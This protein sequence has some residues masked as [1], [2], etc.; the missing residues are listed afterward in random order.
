MPTPSY[1]QPIVDD[2]LQTVD[3]V[4]L[5]SGPPDTYLN[6]AQLSGQERLD[7]DTLFEANERVFPLDS[8][9]KMDAVRVVRN[10]VLVSFREAFAFKLRTRN[11]HY[12]QAVGGGTDVTVTSSAISDSTTAGRAMLTAADAGVQ[13]AF[14]GLGT[15]ATRPATDFASASL[16]VDATTSVKGLVKLAGGDIGGT[17]DSVQVLK[18]NGVAVTGTPVAGSVLTATSDTAAGWSALAAASLTTSGVV[19]LVDLQALGNNRKVIDGA[20]HIGRGN[21][22]NAN[23]SSVTAV[24]SLAYNVGLGTGATAVGFQALGTTTSTANYLTAVGYKAGEGATGSDLAAVGPFAAQSATGQHIVAL[25]SSAAQFASGPYSIHIGAAAGSYSSASNSMFAGPSAGQYATNSTHLVALGQGSARNARDAD[26]IVAIGAHTAANVYSDRV[27]AI[28]TN[29]GLNAGSDSVMVG[30]QAV[31]G[32]S[33]SPIL[34]GTIMTQTAPGVF[35]LSSSIPGA[36]VGAYVTV[37]VQAGG[38]HPG[39][40]AGQPMR[41]LINS[42]TELA[43][44]VNR[45]TASSNSLSSGSTHIYTEYVTNNVTAVGANAGQWSSASNA[46]YVGDTAGAYNNATY[47]TLIGTAAGMNN[48]GTS[49]TAYGRGAATNNNAPNV[50]S[51]GHNSYRL[52]INGNG[53]TAI[54]H[55]TAEEASDSVG[56]VAIGISALRRPGASGGGTFVGAF[57]SQYNTGLYCTAIGNNAGQSVIGSMIGSDGAF[58][59]TQTDVSGNW[60]I[61]PALN[62]SYI[63]KQ[64]IVRV[65]SAGTHTEFNTVG[66]LFSAKVIT[67]T[68]VN[69]NTKRFVAAG[70]NG[71]NATVTLLELPT[72]DNATSI[73]ANS[74]NDASNQVTL[75][76]TA[77]TELKVGNDQRFSIDQIRSAATNTALAKKVVNGKHVVEAVPLLSLAPDYITVAASRD[78]TAFDDDCVLVCAAGITLTIPAALTMKRGFV[79]FPAVGGSVTISAPVT[80]ALNDVLGATVT[81]SRINNTSGVG[82]MYTGTTDRWGVSGDDG[83][84]ATLPD[85]TSS[86]KGVLM[87]A[88]DIGGAAALPTVSAIKGVSTPTTAP[89]VGQ[90]LISTSPTQMAWSD[91]FA[92][93]TASGV[94]NLVDQQNLGLNRKVID[95][96]VIGRGNPLLASRNGNTII[97][98]QSNNSTTLGD[99]VTAIGRAALGSSTVDVSG[100]TAVGNAAGRANNKINFTGVGAWAGELNTGQNV[101]AVGQ[102]AGQRNTALNGTFVGTAAGADN[103]GSAA[104]GMGTAALQNNTGANAIGVGE[105]AGYFNTGSNGV[106]L[107][108]QT[109]RFGTSGERQLFIGTQTG[110][111]NIATDYVAIGAYAGRWQDSTSNYTVALGGFT[112]NN[113]EGQFNTIVGH[114]AGSLRPTALAT[115]VTITQVSPGVFTISPALA[116]IPATRLYAVVTGVT[117]TPHTA[118]GITSECPFAFTSTT[119]CTS[120]ASRFSAA[121]NGKTATISLYVPYTVSNVT[122]VGANSVPLSSNQ[123]VLGDS[124][125]TSLKVGNNLIVDATSLLAATGGERV[126]VRVVNGRKTVVADSNG[127]ISKGADYT[128]L[129]TD[130]ELKF[131]CATALV[132]TINTTSKDTIWFPP[133]VG[134]MTIRAGVGVTLNGASADQVRALTLNR[135]GVGIFANPV[136]A[137]DFTVTGF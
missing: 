118:L 28:G 122:L 111:S 125:V 16:V 13:R 43:G 124:S 50:V 12:T 1:V 41:F 61:S 75:G 2:V 90:F 101:V 127:Y 26:H 9:G 40:G 98:F 82:V 109:K 22:S 64:I 99:N 73:G 55:E 115:N 128:V 136:V 114:G 37:I 63:G 56:T 104:T 108:Y 86:V 129:D 83:S 88:G 68:T 67:T 18:L 92:S 33:P 7:V 120:L 39:L 10:D 46:L 24:G 69:T 80:V 62:A 44:D 100:S 19:N 78:V 81:Y 126:A 77:V 105:G 5:R 72:Y 52:A 51:V 70:N 79:A 132:V 48:T 94:V 6:W 54:G 29:A 113:L 8:D 30:V 110:M 36:V 93:N 102:S 35:S 112:A 14:L 91:A 3:A 17:A 59:A 20:V 32:R 65:S 71:R 60:T 106:F 84:L 131:A 137:G 135:G 130:S 76:D 31:M 25:G 21:P 119:D 4:V 45:F 42:A 58:T 23:R 87:L 34:S 121:D 96:I 27:V 53:F 89:V 57:A 97:G 11:H 134:N 66:A 47:V 38:T 85:A 103:T 49:L 123:I 107:G 116:S 133:A 95:T 15:A 117:A 74:R